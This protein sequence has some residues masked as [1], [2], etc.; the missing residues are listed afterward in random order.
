M[1]ILAFPPE[2][3]SEGSLFKLPEETELAEEKAVN[4]KDNIVDWK[5]K[6]VVQHSKPCASIFCWSKK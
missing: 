6:N 3:P 5:N 1:T 4:Q 2:H